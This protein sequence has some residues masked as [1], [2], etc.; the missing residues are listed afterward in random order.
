MHCVGSCHNSAIG[1]NAIFPTSSTWP[2]NEH[3]AP[4]E[5]GL[6]FIWL[7]GFP[8]VALPYHKVRFVIQINHYL[9]NTVTLYELHVLRKDH[10]RSLLL[11]DLLTYHLWTYNLQLSH[12]FLLFHIHNMLTSWVHCTILH[13]GYY[14]LIITI[15]LN[16]FLIQIEM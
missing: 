11:G 1:S 6:S 7:R 8:I 3:F 2:T 16:R 5:N 13:K 10:L 9:I 15:K 14:H 12:C 4:T